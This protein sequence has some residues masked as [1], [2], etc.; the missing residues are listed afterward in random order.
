ML[1]LICTALYVWYTSPDEEKE[2]KWDYIAQLY[3][4]DKKYG[5]WLAPKLTDSHIQPT[6]FEKMKAKYATQVFSATVSAG[7]NLY[8]RFCAIPAAAMASTELIAK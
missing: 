6:Y 5:I 3:N 8:V 2:I 7:L 4:N 1:L